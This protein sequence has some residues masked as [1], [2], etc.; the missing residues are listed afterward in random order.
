[1][2]SFLLTTLIAAAPLTASAQ[3]QKLELTDPAWQLA[4][5]DTKVETHLGRPAL[6]LRMGT[7][8]RPD[9][10]FKDGTI[11]FDMAL[12]PH[13]AF[14]YVQF[15]IQAEGEHEEYYFRSHKSELPDA[16]QYTPV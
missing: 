13:R 8:L 16:I 1:M 3:V 4:G 9:V 7:A 11:E 6:R 12:T 14:I 2:R 5:D 15:R 10:V